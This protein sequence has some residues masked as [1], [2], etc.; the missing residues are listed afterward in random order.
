MPLDLSP[1][2]LHVLALRLARECRVIVQ[3]CLR[4]EEWP[5]ADAEFAEII[6]AGISEFIARRIEQLS[7]EA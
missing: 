7:P 2:E 6:Q 4:E 3:S 1:I 5:D